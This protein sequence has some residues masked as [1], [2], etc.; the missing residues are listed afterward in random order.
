[1]SV[2]LV[3][4]FCFSAGDVCFESDDEYSTT[5]KGHDINLY[6]NGTSMDLEDIILEMKN[7]SIDVQ[8]EEEV[9]RYLEENYGF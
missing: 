9:L 4:S 1:M 2:P 7:A 5:G 6:Y 3:S 8:S